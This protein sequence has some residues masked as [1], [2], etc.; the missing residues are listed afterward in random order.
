MLITLDLV[1]GF[2]PWDPGYQAAV[3]GGKIPS[4]LL[5]LR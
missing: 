5:N 1:L 3:L 2:L 4:V